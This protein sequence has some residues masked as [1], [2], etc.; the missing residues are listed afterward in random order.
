MRTAAVVVE[1]C[2]LG[3][4]CDTEVE[5][6]CLTGWN[7]LSRDM[8]MTQ[9]QRAGE[10]RTTAIHRH[11]GEVAGRFSGIFIYFAD[12]SILFLYNLV[13]YHTDRIAS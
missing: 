3:K 10:L 5:R 2:I 6:T 13:R 1:E 4:G 9:R 8:R 7:D 12:R 11:K